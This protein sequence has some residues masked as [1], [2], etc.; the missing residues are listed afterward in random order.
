MTDTTITD[1]LQR[2]VDNAYAQHA[3]SDQLAWVIVVAAL[4]LVGV[5]WW[6]YNRRAVNVR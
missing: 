1:E 4:V 5:A 2:L 3:A 6:F